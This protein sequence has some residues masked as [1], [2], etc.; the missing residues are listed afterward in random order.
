V[1]VVSELPHTATGR[2]AKHRLP[3]GLTG[4]EWDADS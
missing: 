3:A 1:Q 2:V 4:A